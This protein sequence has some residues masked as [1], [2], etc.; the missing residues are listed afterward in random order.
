[1]SA[2]SPD[3]RLLSSQQMSELAGVST[4]TLSRWRS[5]RKGPPWIRLSA[6]NVGYPLGQYRDWV[7]GQTITGDPPKRDA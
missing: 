2:I 5:Q 7:R 1:M 6:S 3:D 4:V